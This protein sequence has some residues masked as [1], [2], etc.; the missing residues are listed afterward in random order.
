MS[1][2]PTA[3]DR[4]LRQAGSGVVERIPGFSTARTIGSNPPQTGR[5]V[6]ANPRATVNTCLPGWHGGLRLSAP[7]AT[8]SATGDQNGGDVER[9]K[10]RHDWLD[11]P[12]LPLNPARRLALPRRPMAM[13]VPRPN[14][15]QLHDACNV[16]VEL[17][18]YRVG[19]GNTFRVQLLPV[20][21]HQ[22]VA[23]QHADG[24][25]G[26]TVCWDCTRYS[27]IRTEQARAQG[28]ARGLGLVGIWTFGWLPPVCGV[29]APG[30]KTADFSQISHA[31]A[32]ASARNL[33]NQQSE[34]VPALD[35]VRARLPLRGW[36]KPPPQRAVGVDC[37]PA[38]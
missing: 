1:S 27:L 32:P 18:R 26:D 5:P 6:L 14:R 8:P 34:I 15:R 20:P 10:G 22:A 30:S 33:R 31:L 16:S 12:E 19:T 13:G 17:C 35:N 4:L 2:P 38:S 3:H 24:T 21:A 23:H 29:L 7:A 36:V 28:R 9:G 25:C 11:T 37:L